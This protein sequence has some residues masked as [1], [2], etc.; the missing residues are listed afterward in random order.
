MS[1][2][3][4]RRDKNRGKGGYAAMGDGGNIIYVNTKKKLVVSIAALFVPKTR[5]R[6]EWIKKN[7]EPVYE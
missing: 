5:D 7:I 4:K 6:I 2:K 3:K 1:R